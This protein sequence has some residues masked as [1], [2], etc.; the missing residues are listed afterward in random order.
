MQKSSEREAS[1]ISPAIHEPISLLALFLQ[2]RNT[3]I[4]WLSTLAIAAHL[5]L[6]FA[7]GA[8]LGSASIPLYIALALGGVPLALELLWRVVK[9][10]FGSDLLAGIAIV[11]SIL[12]GEYL[13]GTIVVLMLSGGGALENYAVRNASSVLEPSPGACLRSRIASSSRN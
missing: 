1:K 6:R 9:G 2:H 3:S 11:T 12:L 8:S 10:E 5:I 13:A 7:V 4:A